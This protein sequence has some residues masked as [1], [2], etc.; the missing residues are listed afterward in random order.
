MLGDATGLIGL[1]RSDEMPFQLQ[2]GQLGH[3][4]QRFLEV[5]L[6]E[7]ALTGGGQRGD[8]RRWLSLADRQQ[9]HRARWTLEALLGGANPAQHGVQADGVIGGHHGGITLAN[10]HTV[11]KV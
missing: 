10:W 8:G 7:I 6:P 11:K 5:I 2:R 1:H 4:I 3:F 9:P